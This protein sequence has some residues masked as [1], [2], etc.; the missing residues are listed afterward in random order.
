M[1]RMAAGILV[2]VLGLS[3]AAA[4]EGKDKLDTPAEQ[5][6][7]LLKE[8]LDVPQLLSKAN[9][10]EERKKIIE[11]RDTLPSKFL[12]LAEK[13]PTDPIAVDAL[14][15]M[16]WRSMPG[17]D[18]ALALLQRDHVR[19]DRL[20]Q[21]HQQTA[22]GAPQDVTIMQQVSSFFSKE[23]ETFL[24]TVLEMNPHRDI[25]GNACLALARFQFSRLQRPPTQSA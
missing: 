2:L 1:G 7:A 3:L 20:R 17:S 13:N 9:G 12:E 10:D 5:Y 8:Y 4:E 22:F 21:V 19:S 11:R 16:V 18:R 15:E 25:Q 24:R 14:I 6:Q 23:G